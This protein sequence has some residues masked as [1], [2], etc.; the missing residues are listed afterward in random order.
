M[1]SYKKQQYEKT[2][3][4]E[5]GALRAEGP[6]DMPINQRGA[7][8]TQFTET[9]ED[10]NGKLHATGRQDGPEGFR[11]N[12]TVVQKFEDTVEG[13]DGHLHATGPAPDFAE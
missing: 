11:A 7:T 9:T 5:G 12:A 3:E 2:V 8:V 13:E 1:A 10:E 6:E 4:L